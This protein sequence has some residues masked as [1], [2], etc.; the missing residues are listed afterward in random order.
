ME[1]CPLMAPPKIPMRE[2]LLRHRRI[3]GGHWIWTGAKLPRGYGKIDGTT[4]HRAAFQVFVRP[5]LPDEDAHHTC[6]RNDCFNPAHLKA[7]DRIQH[8]SDH[9]RLD[10]A[11]GRGH[12]RSLHTTIKADGTRYCRACHREAQRRARAAEGSTR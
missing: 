4:A 9:Q 7:K 1:V 2:R 6:D 3:E 10:E 8:R 12:L 5:L 11:C